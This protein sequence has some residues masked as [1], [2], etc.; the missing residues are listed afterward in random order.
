MN[1]IR[2]RLQ[3]ER[4]TQANDH[5]PQKTHDLWCLAVS[6]GMFIFTEYF[7][8]NPVQ[9]VLNAPVVMEM[10]RYLL[11]CEL[12]TGN[13]GGGLVD[14]MNLPVLVPVR[15]SIPMVCTPSQ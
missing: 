3:L 4:I 1:R 12:S 13:E 15:W 8:L 2:D 14:L 9:V 7:I 11:G 6:E 5:A 10:D